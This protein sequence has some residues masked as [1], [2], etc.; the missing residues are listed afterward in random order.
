MNTYSSKGCKNFSKEIIGNLEFSD[1]KLC[2]FYE[3]FCVKY[4]CV[5]VI[6]KHVYQQEPKSTALNMIVQKAAG[7]HSSWD[8]QH[9]HLFN[10]L[11]SHCIHFISCPAPPYLCPWLRQTVIA[12][13]LSTTVNYFSYVL[14]HLVATP[15]LYWFR[16]HSLTLV[17]MVVAVHL[18]T[19]NT[20]S[21]APRNNE[22]LILRQKR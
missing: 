19:I 3:V 6:K 9:W 4:G 20:I 15:S 22:I 2:L 13:N 12:L 7:S 5:E 8:G 21:S 11:L 17:C 14:K 16:K 1:R 18:Q 10:F